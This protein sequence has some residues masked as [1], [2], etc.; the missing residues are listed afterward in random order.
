[1]VGEGVCAAVISEA[2]A[3]WTEPGFDD[4]QWAVATEHSAR[5][6]SPKDGYDAIDWKPG[7]KLIWGNDLKLDNTLL[8]RTVI[9]R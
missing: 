2:P 1:M 4:S 5:E 3:G 9:D 8:C 7:A 6:V